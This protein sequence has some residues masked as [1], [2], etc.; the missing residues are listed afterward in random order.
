MLFGLLNLNKPAGISSAAALARVKPLV[1]PAKLGHA[2]T[3]DPIASGV[4]VVAIGPATRLID[5]VQAMPKRYRAT[6]R[7]GRRSPSDDVETEAVELEN[8]PIPDLPTL[9]Q[10]VALFVGEIQQRPPA[11]SAVKVAGRRAYSLARAG[12]EFELAARPITVHQLDI[13]EYEYPR[14]VLDIR[15]GSG[16]YVRSLGRDLAESLGTAAVMSELVRTAVGPFC[17]EEACVLRELNRDSLARRLLPALLAIEA[18]LPV[19]Q[20]SAVEVDRLSNGLSASEVQGVPAGLDV[21]QEL[22]ALD[23]QGTLA[24]IVRLCPDGSLAPKINFLMDRR[25]EPRMK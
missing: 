9:R 2:G 19:V 1:R 25:E 4:L 24:A 21:G 12:R 17:V 14:L 16:T 15:C 11:F 7:L 20:L 13:V 10:A 6:F 8:P 18:A 22:A 5:R 23:P 3:L